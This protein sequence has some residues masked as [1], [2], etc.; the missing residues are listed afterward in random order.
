VLEDRR[1]LRIGAHPGVDELSQIAG[2][3]ILGNQSFI[4]QRTEHSW[5]GVRP[6]TCPEGRFRKVFIVV[7]NRVN[8]QVRW[9]HLRGK[10]ADGY[11]LR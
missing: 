7:V 3:E 5:H 4:F 1:R 11:P 8:L 6:L 2:S 10:D 9:R